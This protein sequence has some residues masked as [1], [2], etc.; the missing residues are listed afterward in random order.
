VW[1]RLW[2]WAKEAW[3][4]GVASVKAGVEA[5]VNAAERARNTEVHA[6]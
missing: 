6:G 2:E 1:V 4:A 5:R 3:R